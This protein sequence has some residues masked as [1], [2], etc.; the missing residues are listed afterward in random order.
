VLEALRAAEAGLRRGLLSAHVREQVGHVM[1]LEPAQIDPLVPLGS[2]G[3]D[4]LMGLEI[5]NRLERSLG[6]T[7]SAALVWT[8]PTI[9]AMAAFLAEALALPAETGAAA[10]RS[11]AQPYDALAE[12]R[13]QIADLSEAE[14]ERRL[15]EELEKLADHPNGDS[16]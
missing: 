13:A 5:R 16:R 7:L 4:S 9:A 8:Y 6:L 12:A 14:A 2:L 10:N 3:L 15:L 11:A 1:R